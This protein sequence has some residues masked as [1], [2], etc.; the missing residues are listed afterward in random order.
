MRMAQR[1]A[2]KQA[3]QPVTALYLRV[4]NKRS[5]CSLRQMRAIRTRAVSLR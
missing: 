4:G 1:R 5:R 2:G 3:G